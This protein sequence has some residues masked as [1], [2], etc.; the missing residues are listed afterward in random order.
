MKKIKEEQIGGF[1]EETQ[2]LREENCEK[3]SGD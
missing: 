2:N 1:T 3:E